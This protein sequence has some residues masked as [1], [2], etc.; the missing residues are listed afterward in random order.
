[1]A[2]C[3]GLIEQPKHAPLVNISSVVG[4]DIE[5]KVIERLSDSIPGGA[6]YHLGS[7]R[8]ITWSP[9]DE[10]DLMSIAFA[11]VVDSESR[12]LLVQIF[13]EVLLLAV[14][15]GFVGNN[16]LADNPVDDICVLLVIFELCVG[17]RA[18][19]RNSDRR[20]HICRLKLTAGNQ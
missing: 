10:G 16:L 11:E 8:G 19:W 5:T 12:T 7:R 6:V 4:I 20:S 17:C 13:L 3:F 9:R 1:M 14:L 15:G 18:F 2:V